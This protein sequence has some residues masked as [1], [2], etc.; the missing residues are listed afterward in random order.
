MIRNDHEHEGYLKEEL[1]TLL[2]FLRSDVAGNSIYYDDYY[3]HAS[4]Y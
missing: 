4:P 3:E 1:D 2:K